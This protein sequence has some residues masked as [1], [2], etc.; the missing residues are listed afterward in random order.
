MRGRRVKERT[1]SGARLYALR[2]H[3]RL[4]G[5]QAA[6]RWGISAARL[7]RY[8]LGKE[9]IK[10]DRAVRIAQLEGVSLDWLYGLSDE[11]A[12]V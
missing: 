1:G 11:G 5:V 8:E 9:L 3:M 12:P 6:E 2:M 4:T 10:S 7:N